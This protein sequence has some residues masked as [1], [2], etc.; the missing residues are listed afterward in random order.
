M[1]SQTVR[2]AQTIRHKGM[3][4]KF[5][6]VDNHLLDMARRYMLTMQQK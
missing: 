5:A 4:A 2:A 6:G 3:Q 1:T